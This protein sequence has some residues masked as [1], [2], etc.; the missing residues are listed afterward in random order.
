MPHVLRL[1]RPAAHWFASDI[2]LFD[3]TIPYPGEAPTGNSSKLFFSWHAD[4]SRVDHIFFIRKASKKQARR[5][6]CADYAAA[7][8]R[9]A[10]SLETLLTAE[11]AADLE[12]RQQLTAGRGCL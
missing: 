4:Q 6:K 5:R 2:A 1:P 11:E 7:L 8:S 3:S 9:M 12:R 10:A